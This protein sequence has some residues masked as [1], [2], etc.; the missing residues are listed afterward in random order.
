MRFLGDVGVSTSTLRTLR[1][2]CYDAVH[3]REQNLHRLP[4]KA[5]LEKA[6][7]EG[8]IVIT[9]DLDFGDLLATSGGRLP[10]VII[11]RLYNQTPPN[12]TKRLF[13]LLS[14][15]TQRLES[16]ALFIVEDARY[17]MRPLPIIPV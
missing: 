14:V 16:G 1:E 8:R 13:D 11:F 9:F 17:R 15:E 4:D 12:V 2:A 7:K 10:S 5:I 6:L 3:L